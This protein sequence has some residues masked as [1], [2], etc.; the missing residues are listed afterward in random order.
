MLQPQPRLVLSELWRSATTALSN[1]VSNVPAVLVLKS[2]VADHL[3]HDGPTQ[4]RRER[5]AYGVQNANECFCAA[6]KLVVAM[7]DK[8]QARD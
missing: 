1:L 8:A 3:D 2:F 7:F 5:H 4:H 6:G